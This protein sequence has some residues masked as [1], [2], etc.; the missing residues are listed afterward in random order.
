MAT[1]ISLLEYQI[2]NAQSL[3]DLLEQEKVAIANRVSKDIESLAKNK[4]DLINQLQQTDQRIGEHSDIDQLK[5][6]NDFENKVSQIQSLVAECQ[7]MNEINGEALQRAQLS[8]NKLHN[9]MQQSRSKIGMTYNA[10]GQTQTVSTL[11]T[12]IKA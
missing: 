1:L 2:Q 7:Q 3:S 9:L 12:N 10:G 8:F 6:N 11:G 5:T 4:L